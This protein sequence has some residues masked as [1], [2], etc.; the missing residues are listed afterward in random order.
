M[1]TQTQSTIDKED[2]GRGWILMPLSRSQIIE[3]VAYFPRELQHL[4][5]GL[6]CNS[7]AHAVFL[8]RNTTEA[9]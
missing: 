2:Q 5:N 7:W 9:L 4:I 3:T 8:P 6:T 1:F